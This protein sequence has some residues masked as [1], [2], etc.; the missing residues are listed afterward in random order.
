MNE[1][2]E[3]YKLY[4]VGRNWVA[5][6]VVVG[7]AGILGLSQPVFVH[8]DTV[9]PNTAVKASSSSVKE[10]SSTAAPQVTSTAAVTS[11]KTTSVVSE[12]R[13]SNA[14]QR[15]QSSSTSNETDSASSV[16]KQATSEVATSSSTSQVKTSLTTP[17]VM[18]RAATSANTSSTN[19]TT[20]VN[21]YDSATPIANSEK[22]H[23]PTAG[24]K[25]A[26]TYTFIPNANFIIKLATF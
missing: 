3:H 14:N 16:T 22:A 20:G 21:D 24:E 7:T 26:D 2:K 9:T 23:V 15:G 18:K 5:A 19:D 1:E 6:L 10:T 17:K 12:A 25:L 13:V 8:A 11:K 4:K